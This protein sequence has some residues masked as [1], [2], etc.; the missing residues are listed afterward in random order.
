[1][2]LVLAI[3]TSSFAAYPS[4]A[5]SQ[6][7]PVPATAPLPQFEGRSPYTAA[8]ARVTG[9]SGA[10]L[11]AREGQVV[12]RRAFGDANREFA[13]PNSPETSSGSALR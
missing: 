11:V 13:V 7:S 8:R 2:R 12:F 1:M 3:L 4:L 6:Q 5:S 10:V 9:F